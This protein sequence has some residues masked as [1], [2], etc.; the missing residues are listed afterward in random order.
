ML[1]LFCR[2]FRFWRIL[3]RFWFRRGN[4]GRASPRAGTGY[5]GCSAFGCIC[6][7]R[8]RA[9]LV[10][11]LI[12]G[13]HGVFCLAFI[14]GIIIFIFIALLFL[15]CDQ[16]KDP[17]ENHIALFALVLHVACSNI[18]FI[19]EF[20]FFI[21][22]SFCLVLIALPCFLTSILEPYDNNPGG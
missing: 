22:F 17:G 20:S 14:L 11:H 18:A 16:V 21:I 8:H 12:G 10:Q 1:C 5:W 13:I 15:M 7:S 2:I 4:Q 19:G 6:L 3:L 9:M